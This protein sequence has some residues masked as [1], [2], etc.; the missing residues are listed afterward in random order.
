M[1]VF[2]LVHMLYASMMQGVFVFVRSFLHI[3]VGKLEVAV[4]DQVGDEA[5]DHRRR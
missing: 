4:E 5:V 2:V 1:C 3:L